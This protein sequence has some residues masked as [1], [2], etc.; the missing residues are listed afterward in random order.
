[1][2]DDE[3]PDIRERKKRVAQVT[4]TLRDYAV[5]IL[6]ETTKLDRAEMQYYYKVVSCMEQLWDGGMLLQKIGLPEAERRIRK[7]VRPLLTAALEVR[8]QAGGQVHKLWF[9]NK[10][11][12]YSGLTSLEKIDAFVKEWFGEQTADEALRARCLYGLYEVCEYW[13][14]HTYGLAG[15]PELKT[16]CRSVYVDVSVARLRSNHLE[17][18][19]KEMWALQA[20]QDA[21]KQAVAGAAATPGTSAAAE[22]IG[23]LLEAVAVDLDKLVNTLE[24]TR[25]AQA[26]P[27]ESDAPEDL[28]DPSGEDLPDPSGELAVAS[29]SAGSDPSIDAIRTYIA[30]VCDD[31]W[32]LFELL[33]RTQVGEHNRRTNAKRW[34]FEGAVEFKNWKEDGF[35]SLLMSCVIV[36]FHFNGKRWGPSILVTRDGNDSVL[37]MLD[38]PKWGIRHYVQEI[39]DRNLTSEVSD[40]IRTI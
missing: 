3:Y 36:L 11:G 8:T 16:A 26:A 30:K 35:R 40:D 33:P 25:S 39:Q 14:T 1:M 27:A 28:L 20:G 17:T 13:T 2:P 29:E 23:R 15:L 9:M 10:D 7:E 21:F 38:H 34:R 18:V 19:L 12:R 24:Q 37:R 6:P 4:T 32:A 5:M 22:D 31:L